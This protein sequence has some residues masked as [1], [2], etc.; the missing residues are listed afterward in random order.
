M[1]ARVKLA[2][3]PAGAEI[4]VGGHRIE[5]GI[6]ALT[7]EAFAGGVP[8]I[9]LELGVAELVDI[10]GDVKLAMTGAVKKAL[11]ALGWTPPP[12]A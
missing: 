5:N 11:I 8:Q 6:R 10:E 12:E 7:V 9:R 4:E 1:R 3:S 2:D